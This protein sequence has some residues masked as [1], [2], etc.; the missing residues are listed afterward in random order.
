PAL[1]IN[2]MMS[3]HTAVAEGAGL[4]V[5][6]DYIVED[7]D[8]LVQIDI[9]TTLPQYDLY[10]VYAEE[11]RNSARVQAFRDFVLAKAETW[12]Y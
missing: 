6:P 12:H 10:F 4:G 3:L 2:N 5:L 11:L 7:D 1:R 9:G 8:R